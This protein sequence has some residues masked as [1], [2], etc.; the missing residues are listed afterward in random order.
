MGARTAGVKGQSPTDLVEDLAAALETRD[1]TGISDSRFQSDAAYLA[2]RRDN[3]DS[4]EGRSVR[5]GRAMRGG[6][7]SWV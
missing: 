2:V 4:I 1:D 6:A 7:L 3:G 5:D